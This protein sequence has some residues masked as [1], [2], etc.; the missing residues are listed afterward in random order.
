ME[1]SKNRIRSN[2]IILLFLLF[3][4]SSAASAGSEPVFTFSSAASAGIEECSSCTVYMGYLTGNMEM[5]KRGM[6]ELQEQFRREPDV[7][8]FYTLVEARYGYIGY[9]LG[10]ED[11]DAA[12]SQIETFTGEIEKLAAYPG[13]E[14]ET[15][16]FRLALLGFRMGLNPARV[17]TLGPKALKQLEAT[18]KVG[19]GSPAAWIEKANSESHMPAFAGGSGEK[20]AASFREALRLFEADPGLHACSWRYLNTMVLLGQL[21]E[22]M[23]DYRGAAETYRMAL[24]RAPDFRW[25]RDELLPAVE[26]RLK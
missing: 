20:A 11:K 1:R 19:S 13:Y 17:V 2:L 4:F 12:R 9:L 7:C 8:T 16:A 3:A 25:V 26:K 21:L 6:A 23:D 24:K 15:E 14:A 5:W 18:M 10:G 22:R